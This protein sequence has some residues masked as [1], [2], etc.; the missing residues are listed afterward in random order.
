MKGKYSYFLLYFLLVTKHLE[1]K[2]ENTLSTYDIATI[3]YTWVRVFNH[4]RRSGGWF[5]CD[6]PENK[7]QRRSNEDDPDAGRFSILD[8]MDKYKKDG[9]F[10]IKLCY[11]E[12][13]EEFPCN[14]WTQ[15]SNF[16][17]DSEIFH[18]KPLRITYKESFRGIDFEGLKLKNNYPQFLSA[19]GPYYYFGLGYCQRDG[20]HFTGPYGKPEVQ[21]LEIYLAAGIINL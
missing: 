4:D 18:Y 9:V 13:T 14:E 10:H 17:R 19:S 20:S 3:G 12:Y 5:P 1:G 6:N 2:M 15:S 21:H 16:E 11:P 8:E 7:E